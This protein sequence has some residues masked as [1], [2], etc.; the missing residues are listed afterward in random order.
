[1]KGWWVE[2]QLYSFF[3]QGARFEWETNTTPR[4]LYSRKRDQVLVYEAGWAPG[5]V[6]TGAENLTPPPGLDPKTVQPVVSSNNSAIPA[7]LPPK[8]H[9]SL[10]EAL[11]SR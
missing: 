11:P 2:V 10:S 1:M 6:W 5:P 9:H 4:P 8:W 3:N 7:P